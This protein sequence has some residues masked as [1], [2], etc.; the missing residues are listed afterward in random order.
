VIISRTPLR[1]SFF[2]GG[3]DY[4]AW[5][6]RGP[7]ATLGTTIDKYLYVSCRHLPPFFEHSI[8]ISYSRTECVRS[9]GD[10]QHPAVRE[11]LQFMD[12]TNEVEIHHDSDLPART[13]LGSSSAFTVGMLHALHAYKGT[14]V[15]KDRL[16]RDAIH[17]EQDRLGERVGCQ[18]QILAAYGGLRLLEITSSRTFSARP[19]TTTA[20]R[21]NTLQD[22]MLLL[23]T[24]ISRSASE[25]VEAQLSLID[26]KVTELTAMYQL[27]S[28]AADV[29]VGDGPIEEF[30]RLLHEGW[31]LKRSLSPRVST[32][33]VDDA[34]EAARREGAIGGK[35]LGAGGGGF[36]LV[37]ADPALHPRIVE[38]L[39]PLVPVRFRFENSGTQIIFYHPNGPAN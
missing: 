28:V 24:G 36:L 12:V 30:G 16:A 10:I 14:M 13:G 33:L 37:F 18:D 31:L 34:Y 25:I 20:S 23:Y 21:L 35:L 26:K 17:V 5:L 8:R 1:I 22:S 6:E 7:G 27:V 19:I 38:R 15:T 39:K 2:G 9:V 11:C 4:P 3:T 29:L 32:A